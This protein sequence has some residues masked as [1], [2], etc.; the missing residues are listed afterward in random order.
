MVKFAFDNVKI[1]GISSVIPSK[2]LCLLDDK[3]L[4]NGD[5][6]R[7]NRVIKSSGFLK[8][9][10]TESDIMTSDLCLQAANDL[11]IDLKIKKEEIDALLFLSYTPDYL[12]PATSYVLHNKLGLSK[13]IKSVTSKVN[14]TNIPSCFTKPHSFNIIV[15]L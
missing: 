14:G 9:R 8:R 5:E 12:M 15:A 7:I 4:Y 1:S 10:V 11:I 2:E 3:N 13:S 6:K